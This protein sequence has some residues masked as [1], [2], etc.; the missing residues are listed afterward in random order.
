MFLHKFWPLE[1]QPIA[2]RN[3]TSFLSAQISVSSCTKTCFY[4]YKDFNRSIV[5]YIVILPLCVSCQSYIQWSGNKLPLLCDHAHKTSNNKF[6]WSRSITSLINSTL[7]LNLRD[8]LS[9]SSMF[10]NRLSS[11]VLQRQG[12]LY[13]FIHRFAAYRNF[14]ETDYIT[15]Y[16]NIYYCA[17]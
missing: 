10:F 3:I 11:D 14:N 9:N 6:H 4:D 5:L 17:Y 13:S 16:M 15:S 12:F 2:N 1:T 7:P 8:I